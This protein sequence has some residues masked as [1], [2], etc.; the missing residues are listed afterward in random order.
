MSNS[1]TSGQRNGLEIAIIGLSCRFPGANNPNEFWSN[2]RD[3]VESVSFF[4]DEELK[5]EGFGAA[6]LGRPD[7]VR[8]RAVLEDVDKFDAS[9]FRYTPREAEIMDPQ[10]R[11]F[12][13]CAWEA[14]EDAGYDPDRFKESIGVY[15][16]ATA[17]GYF[18]TNIIS[19]KELFRTVGEF[20]LLV[21][22]LKDHLPTTVSYKLNLKGPSV[23]VQASCSTSLVAVH[24]ACQGLLS[25]ECDMA[26]A[27]GVSVNIPH[28]AGYFYEVGG[29]NSPDGHCRAFDADAHGTVNGNGLGVVVLKRLTDAI[30]DRDYIHAVIKGS[31]INNDGA[32]KLG[33]TAPSVEGQAKVI[34][35]AHI[36]AGVNP[37]TISYIEAHGTGTQMGDPIEI[38]ALTRAFRGSTDRK[39]FCGLGSVKTNIG[40][41]DAAAGIAG[42]IKTVLALK[43]R[44]LPPSLHFKKPNP[45]IDF[46]NSPFYVNASLAEWRVSGGPRRAG[47]SSFGI[48]GTNAHVVV[49]EAPAR[50]ASG[51]SR[52]Y[53]LVV[54][55]AKTVGA[56]ERATANMACHLRNHPD[57]NLGDVVHTLQVG[58]QPFNCRR[59]LVSKDVE[60]TVRALE[61]RDSKR[62]F[63]GSPHTADSSVVFML[64]GVGAQYVNMGR[65]LYLEE[66]V[67]RRIVDECSESVKLSFGYDLHDCIF[68][69]AE[70]T[71]EM[72]SKLERPSIAMPALVTIEYAI[73]TLL[74][75]WGVWPEA[76]IGH[77]LGEYT[78]ACLAG[79]FAIGDALA[80]AALRGRLFEERLPEGAML[81]VAL[82][83]PDVMLLMEGELSI[84]AANGP[85][86]CVVAGPVK[87]VERMAKLLASRQVE[88]QRIHIR[89]AGHS[90]MVDGI[91]E[92][93]TDYV[94]DL[95]LREPEIPFISNVTGTW[96]TPQE[97]T[98]P[99][100][101]G[102][103][104]RET[105][106]FADGIEVLMQS[107]GRIFL[108]VGPGRGL[109]TLTKLQKSFA[110]ERKVLA[111]M[112][113]PYEEHSDLAF[114]LTA[115][116][117]LWISGVGIDWGSFYSNEMRARLSL[118]TY[119]FEERRHWIEWRRTLETTDKRAKTFSKRAVVAD[120]LYMPVWKQ[121]PPLHRLEPG[122]LSDQKLHYLAFV[123]ECGLGLGV[124]KR[125]EEEGQPVVTVT[126]GSFARLSDTSFQIDPRDPHDYTQLLMELEGGNQA[127]NKILHFWNLTRAQRIAS[128]S[129]ELDKECHLG[130][131]SL[132]YLAMAIG[133]MGR[134]DPIQIDVISNGSLEVTG[135]EDL[136]PEK[137]TVLA[138][139]KVIPQEFP[140]I[141]SRCID[142]VLPD[143][144]YGL[145]QVRESLISEITT[146]SEDKILAYRGPNRWVQDFE[147]IR[148]GAKSK[149]RSLLREGGT[150]LITGGLGAIGLDIAEYMARALR[151]KLILVGRSPFPARQAWDNW[152][153]TH[154]DQDAVSIKIRR[155][156]TLEALG[157]EALVLRADVSSLQ[158]M[159]QV[160]DQANE[161]FGGINGVVHAAGIIDQRAYRLIRD[162][163]Q[164]D[165]AVQFKPK[166]QGVLALERVL[167]GKTMDFC[168]LLSSLSSVLGG[169]G[170]VAYSAANLF[171]DS[172]ARKLS[173]N[174][175]VTWI[176]AT[177]DGWQRG[178]ETV[179]K[180]GAGAALAA[181]AMT[182]E[183]GVQVIEDVL[184]NHGLPQVIVSTGDLQGRIDQWIK[185]VPLQDSQR[186][187]SRGPNVEDQSLR[188]AGTN[189]PAS[190]TLE[191]QIVE[192]WREHLGVDEIGAQDDF[193]ELGGHSLLAI[194]LISRLRETFRADVS[195]ADL[196][197]SPTVE[198]LAL[199]IIQAKA[200]QVDGESMGEILAELEQLSDDDLRS[201]S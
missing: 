157:A 55:S 146:R 132:V 183:E 105:V 166:I 52:T 14:L 31:A 130:F 27:A 90:K 57:M 18:L 114:L 43:H 115:V 140:N 122:D 73:A 6:V 154:D 109:A 85:T 26:L 148:L 150:Y 173:R 45:N 54:L 8:A 7:F 12:L 94:S 199:A 22:N 147:P 174:G 134:T 9:F 102:R 177:L 119:P 64:P 88:H 112:R 160:A 19:N 79:V 16:G 193:F 78:A 201:R 91:V 181:L 86:H 176:S 49:E 163:T 4:T 188:E 106:R 56:L 44:Q 93:L 67:F 149:P 80:L 46:G 28:K 172:F 200:K 51:V 180:R 120:W 23:N 13:E 118:P 129:Q 145:T 192:L 107:P 30:A 76:M 159:E 60:D 175:T 133:K 144:D 169:L 29:I 153:Q 34:K 68:P 20:Q 108:E 142:V 96:I 40:H 65:D 81:S 155:V 39:G 61:S 35:Q 36:V 21:S 95:R 138:P 11:L 197:R 3:G 72:A 179:E 83:E 185:L 198:G 63:D 42:L 127:P 168:L 47:V 15:A 62:I 82:S 116:G 164:E 69:V 110:P 184:T 187:E 191:Q 41:L 17:E 124:V 101:W 123:D 131:Y 103:Q 143:S 98:D 171:M 77:S 126:M 162:L 136:T 33:Y 25:G 137:S 170:F 161:A 59:I 186:S 195:I 75:S 66:A 70:S 113:H 97:A 189:L 99:H 58:R 196:F 117:R 151:A 190:G 87:S 5:A 178:T 194:K 165:C 100:Y 74:K 182:R 37:E 135:G 2:L 48:G 92:E 38:A 141:T 84:A 71:E 121:S 24:L 89:M 104:L 125:L 139:C 158:Q 53:Q 111:S 32:A 128:T 1:E 167:H 156:L 152:L 50:E 10:Q